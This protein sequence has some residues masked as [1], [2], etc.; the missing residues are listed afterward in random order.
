MQ[1]Q[2]KK[3]WLSLLIGT[4]R[5]LSWNSSKPKTE[6]IPPFNIYRRCSR[7]PMDIF[8]TAL[9]DQDV[10]VLAI[11]DAPLV[12]VQQAWVTILEEYT[13]IKGADPGAE[14]Y[15]NRDIIRLQ[16]HL[17]LVQVCV[18][19]LAKRY[20][21]IIAASLTKL[22]YS[23]KPI[24]K[25]PEHYRND[26]QVVVNRSKT[27]YMTMQVLI[28]QLAERQKEIKEVKSPSR[29][30]F[31]TLLI[32]IEEMQG[33]SYNMETLMVSK[34]VNLEKKYW[35]QVDFLKDKK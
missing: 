22:G 33:T 32:Q 18:D 35:R 16:N 28:K 7:L 17:F 2:I 26:L 3:S 30:Y 15:L 34:F 27:K 10:M 8:L 12:E 25:D 1:L 29:E 24:V 5:P 20:S 31:E 23:F 11:E 13:E 14:W 4:V 6:A 9:C 21:E 19:F